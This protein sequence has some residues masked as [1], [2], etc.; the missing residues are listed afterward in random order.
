MGC[1]D[2]FP[3]DTVPAA[4]RTLADAIREKLMIDDDSDQAILGEQTT[5]ETF[6]HWSGFPQKSEKL[7]SGN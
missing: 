1:E 7:Y 4:P 5:Y 2:I 6:H 3:M